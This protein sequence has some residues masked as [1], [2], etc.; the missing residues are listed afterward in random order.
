[1]PSA[2]CSTAWV[3]QPI[4]R[5]TA[6]VGVNIERGSPA[7]AI[8]TPAKYS[9]LLGSSRSGLMPGQRR[10]H[11]LLDVDGAV[12]EVA[13]EADGDLP[14]E[15]AAGVAA[16]VHGVAEAHDP[17]PGGDLGLDPGLRALGIADG[18]ER[19]EGPAR[20]AAVQRP[21]QRAEGGPDDVGEVG[22]GRRHDAGRERRCVEAV[23]DRQDEVLLQGPGRDLGRPL[24]GHH[25]QVR[26]GVAEVRVGGDGF[27]A[28]AG[29]VQAG[30]QHR[31]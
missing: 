6:N 24:A 25:L 7:A 13:A 23:V 16:A 5:L 8:T 31:A 30:D 19:V 22:P 21:G 26:G 20:R 14:E 10:E 2:A 18:V 9:T 4:V 1:M 27:E 15:V 11:P 17:P 29:P 12:D 28:E 3:T